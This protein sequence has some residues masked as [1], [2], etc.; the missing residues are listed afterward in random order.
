[1]LATSVGYW[2]F[3]TRNILHPARLRDG[4]APAKL[5]SLPL[6]TRAPTAAR[7]CDLWTSL[8]VGRRTLDGER[9]RFAGA[10]QWST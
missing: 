3:G 10:T 2:D 5:W 4:G 9:R 8:Y 1:V 6:G 7:S